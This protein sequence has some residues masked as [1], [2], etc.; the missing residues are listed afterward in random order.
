M[1]HELAPS[2]TL[3]RA[4]IMCGIGLFVAATAQILRERTSCSLPFSWGLCWFA[5]ALMPALFMQGAF[6]EHWLY[7]PS[8]GLFLG[9]AQSVALF[10]EKKSLPTSQFAKQGIVIATLLVAAV[11]GFLTYNQNTIWRE[12]VVFYEHIFA[13]GEKAAKAHGNLATVYMQQG[14]YEK[15]VEQNRIAIENSHDTLATARVNLA[16]ALYALPDGQDHQNEVLANLQRALEIDPDFYGAFDA[17][18]R[19]YNQQKNPEKSAFYRD[20]ADAVRKKFR[21]FSDGQTA[22]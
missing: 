17:L 20:K 21:T 3:W 8:V 18:A 16:L 19:F 14:E 22:F 5:A 6:Y 7:L 15:A 1:G 10:V 13:Q 12:S 9:M 4:D 11:M 2:A